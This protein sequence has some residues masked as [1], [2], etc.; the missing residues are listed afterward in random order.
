M[1]KYFTFFLKIIAIVLAFL[2][3]SLAQAQCAMCRATAE[4]SEYSAGINTGVL[5]LLAFPV[6]VIVGGGLFWYFNR[7]KFQ[8]N[9]WD[10]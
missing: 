2:L 4:N 9:T 6:I 10:N 8:A 1:A 5:Y 7:E 3:P